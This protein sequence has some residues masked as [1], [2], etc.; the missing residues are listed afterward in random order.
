M[1]TAFAQPEAGS[2]RP[3][4]KG[5][6]GQITTMVIEDVKHAAANAPGHCRS[7]PGPSDLG[8]PCTRRLAY[9]MNWPQP[10][11]DTDPWATIIGTAVHAWMAEMYEA[12][13]RAPGHDRY[14]IEHRVYLPAGP[15][16][17]SGS[18]DLFDRDIG[19]VIDWK[20]TGLPNLRKYRASGPGQQY[21][22]QGHQYGLGRQLAGDQPKDIA[23]VFL[24]RGGRIT[25]LYVW[26]EPYH[27]QVAVDAIKRY[28]AT[29]SAVI[30]LDPERYPERW[31][32]FGTADAHCTWCPYHLPMSSDLS[33][34][35]PGHRTTTP[36]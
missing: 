10:N 15:D 11:A 20:V 32:L 35:C 4:V 13:N 26:T 33:K 14:L 3:P 16:G 9:A 24:P 29:R 17:I 18:A 27:P 12:R 2:F 31:A 36:K 6:A 5:V 21:R 30:T 22:T 7:L 28:E 8:T 19:R 34:G 25:D 23:I 1:T